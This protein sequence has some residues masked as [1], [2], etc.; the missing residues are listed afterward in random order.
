M[1]EHEV[2][3]Y[4]SGRCSKGR[5]NAHRTLRAIGIRPGD[6][7]L[8]AGAGFGFLSAAAAPLVGDGGKVY[9]VDI[10]EEGMAA[11]R[12]EAQQ[13]GLRNVEAIVADITKRTPLA[14][15]SVD[16][17]VMLNVLHGFVANG[18]TGKAVSEIARV[19][20]P[21]GTF[22]VV[23]FRKASSRD[24]ILRRVARAV[25]R[26]L[27]RVSRRFAGGPPQT[28][29]LSAEEI[30][31]AVTPHGFR[32]VRTAHVGLRHTMVVFARETTDQHG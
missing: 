30:V 11:L 6:V 28:V 1:S 32:R 24:F 5:L 18:E 31:A 13:K 23:E 16:V 10:Y 26:R 8:D 25:K 21:G 4:H 27:S 22:A 12:A 2:R 20:K 19:V 9:A 7:V 17:C 3:H 15:A 29:R 14:D